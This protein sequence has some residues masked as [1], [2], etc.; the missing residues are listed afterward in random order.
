MSDNQ[1]NE[2][3][4][5]RVRLPEES[6]PDPKDLAAMAA[7]GERPTQALTAYEWLFWFECRDIYQDWRNKAQDEESLRQRK[8]EAV[9]HYEAAKRERQELRDLSA[10]C[11]RLWKNVEDAAIEYRKARDDA[12][13]IDA[14]D[15]MMNVIYGLLGG[16]E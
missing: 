2:R 10:R 15:R 1:K 5:V 6:S 8:Y 13:R 7:R 12:D 9:Q 3:G 16:S 14:A 11:A 4:Q